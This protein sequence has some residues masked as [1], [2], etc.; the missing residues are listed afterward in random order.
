MA[1]LSALVFA[2]ATFFLLG[3][4]VCAAWY[5]P[6]LTESVRL[7]RTDDLTGLGNRRAL[8]TGLR[9]ALRDSRRLSLMLLDLDGFKGVNDRYG[10]GMGD[11]VLR[12]V[13]D[14]LTQVLGK[15]C[16]LARLGGDEFAV[17]VLDDDPARL[18]GLAG[19]VRRP[20][21]G[22][23]AGVGVGQVDGSLNR[24]YGID[25]RGEDACDTL[26]K[27]MYRPAK[28][29]GPTHFSACP[30]T[31]SAESSSTPTTH[32]ST[33]WPAWARVRSAPRPGR[34]RSRSGR[35]AHR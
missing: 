21:R 14:R 7:S 27:Q 8:L 1:A 24:S 33:G 23:C 22:R 15:E 35:P 5:R 34:R 12:I 31:F 4:A 32:R 6:R 26:R 19:R 13:G 11:Q 30:G 16:L 2:G 28:G 29:P 20:W 9:R 3:A 18:L 25:D 10:H 17:M